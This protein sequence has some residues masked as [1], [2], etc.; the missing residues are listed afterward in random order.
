MR[1]D[2]LQ[3]NL[4]TLT[5]CRPQLARRVRELASTPHLQ[6]HATTAGTPTLVVTSP[7]GGRLALHSTENPIAESHA[8]VQHNAQT[9]TTRPL[10]LVMG[11]GLGY[12][13]PLLKQLVPVDSTVV[14]VEPD[15]GIFRCAMGVVD[16]TEL[17]AS[18]NFQW[19]VGEE[20]GALGGLFRGLG[21]E[22]RFAQSGLVVVGLP[23][24][25]QLYRG[26]VETLT[27]WVQDERRRVGLG[28][29][30]QARHAR[31]VLEHMFKNIPRVL[32][33]G[34]V[35]C[36][37]HI[38]VGKP[39][40]VAAAGP[41]LQDSLPV[42]ERLRGKVALLA[43]DTAY[44]VLHEAG[45]EPLAV[46]ATDPSVENVI[47]LEGITASPATLIAY[48]GIHPDLCGPFE[49]RIL[50]HDVLCEGD[51]GSANRPSPLLAHL[52]LTPVLGELH[53]DGSTAHTAISLA[54]YM[55]CA[56]VIC[57]GLDLAYAD[58][59]TYAEGVRPVVR[60]DGELCAVTANDGDQVQTNT[61]YLHYLRRMP[62]FLATLG[63]DAATTSPGAARIEGLRYVP[64]DELELPDSGSI[65]PF[66]RGR[67]PA[68]VLSVFARH[69]AEAERSLRHVA[70]ELENISD[71]LRRLEPKSSGL[72]EA[73]L[74]QMRQVVTLLGRE[75]IVELAAGLCR[76]SVTALSS[77]ET[78]RLLRSAQ[79]DER[80]RAV[81][82]MTGFVTELR[83]AGDEVCEG[84]SGI[85]ARIGTA[86]RNG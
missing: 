54:R 40:V 43:V 66:P 37:R 34:G 6:L 72:A 41:S 59:K 69:V 25:L 33:T 61:V 68:H 45:I 74:G 20:V 52:G 44:P 23:G 28:H 27:V 26:Y 21:I 36:L 50:W 85:R 47:R 7:D 65:S 18:P 9:L 49:D 75:P 64:W 13:L 77:G 4:R 14:V 1:S 79:V 73:G 57:T 58:G 80:E 32:E 31:L 8:W 29:Q 60:E 11:T 53:S 76:T 5:Q 63:V 3:R 78:F 83:Q 15:L 48:P 62:D 67:I 17:I 24:P 82:T 19:S 70:P 56:P 38:S 86:E 12:H 30:T 55:G 81:Q 16:L 51:P 84:L 71:R 10:I 2:L 22:S 39:A 42:L 46:V 35:R